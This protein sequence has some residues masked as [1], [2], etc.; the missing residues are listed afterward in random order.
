[1]NKQMNDDD[2]GDYDHIPDYN[3][4][5]DND[6]TSGNIQFGLKLTGLIRKRAEF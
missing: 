6:G 1:M 3:N 4:D 5:D 2:D